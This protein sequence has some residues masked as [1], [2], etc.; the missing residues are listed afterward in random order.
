MFVITESLLWGTQQIAIL[1]YL[2]S[3]NLVPSTSFRYERK[4]KERPWN[5][6]NTWLKYVQIEGIFFRIN[7]GIR[8][9]WHWKQGFNGYRFRR[10]ICSATDKNKI[11]TYRKRYQWK[12]VHLANYLITS[13]WYGLVF[14]ANKKM[15]KQ[16]LQAGESWWQYSSSTTN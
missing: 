7:S 15:V 4:A 1:F 11:K 2:D 12:F 14:I 8:G 9:R 13:L 16:D 6:S 10:L 3:N 5:T